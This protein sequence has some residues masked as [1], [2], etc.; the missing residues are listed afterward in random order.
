MERVGT[1]F[2]T[3]GDYTAGSTTVLG[4]ETACLDLN[5]RNKRERNIV[6]SVEGGSSKIFNW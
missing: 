1:R 3:N 6:H 5:F 4:F 2:R